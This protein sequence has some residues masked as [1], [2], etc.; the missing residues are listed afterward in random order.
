[1][2]VPAL[3]LS[4]PIVYCLRNDMWVEACAMIVG[5]FMIGRLTMLEWR[6]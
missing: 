6:K 1:M 2:L 5:M 3:L 4:V